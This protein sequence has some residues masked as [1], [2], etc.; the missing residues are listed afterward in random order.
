M[1]GFAGAT[2]RFIYGLSAYVILRTRAE[3]RIVNKLHNMRERCIE[4]AKPSPF[5]N[6]L[7]DL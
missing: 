2:A 4:N 5:V 1:R 3:L 7:K 6:N